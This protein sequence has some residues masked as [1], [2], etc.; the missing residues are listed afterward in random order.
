MSDDDDT[1][2]ATASEVTAA[3]MDGDRCASGLTAT[4]H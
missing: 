2:P 1:V 4:G 3:L